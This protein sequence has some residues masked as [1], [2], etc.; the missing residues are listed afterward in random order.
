M[1]VVEAIQ[2]DLVKRARQGEAE[3]SRVGQVKNYERREGFF[4]ALN[5]VYVLLC[6]RLILV[7]GRFFLL[8]QAYR[9]QV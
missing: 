4:H 7:H 9:L 2:G 8:E 1:C 6:D 5:G 3:L